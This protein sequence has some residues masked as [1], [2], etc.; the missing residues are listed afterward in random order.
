MSVSPFIERALYIGE[1]AHDGQFRKCSEAPYI[2]HPIGVALMLAQLGADDVTIAAALLHDVLEDCPDKY[3]QAQMFSEFGDEV[4]TIVKTVSKNPSITDWWECNTDLFNRVEST[5]DGRAVLVFAA[6]KL[7]NAHATLEDFIND[8]LAVWSRFHTGMDGQLWLYGEAS[9][10][11]SQKLPN[12]P[13]ALMLESQVQELVS[14]V[15]LLQKSIQ[16]W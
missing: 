4:T 12:H 5:E 11:V 9:R 8:G 14:R 6:D 1:Q 13:L 2:V 15:V 10:I 3:S 16:A 7:S